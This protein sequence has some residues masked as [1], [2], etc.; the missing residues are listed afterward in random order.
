MDPIYKKAVSQGLA[1]AI[2]ALMVD[3]HAWQESEDKFSWKLCSK[4][5]IVAFATGTVA[6]TLGAD[7]FSLISTTAPHTIGVI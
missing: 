1:F 4:R 7:T 3:L 2:G 5:V 6:S